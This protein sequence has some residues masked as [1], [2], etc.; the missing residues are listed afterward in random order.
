MNASERSLWQ[1]L[2]RAWRKLPGDE[3][4][5]KRIENSASSGMPD[6]EGHYGE[7]FWL[8]LKVAGRPADPMTPID[9]KH[10]RPKQV[11]WLYNRWLVGGNAWILLRVDGLGG[12]EV[13]LVSGKYAREVRSGLTRREL[14][15]L[16][17]VL[18]C[19]DQMA[20]LREA[21]CRR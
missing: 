21:S 11:E 2:W 15:G 19:A 18:T 4:H 17:T 16:S 3:L 6:A 14:I 7:Q 8:E 1:W 13:F 20:I 5:A 10:L 12:S 9:V